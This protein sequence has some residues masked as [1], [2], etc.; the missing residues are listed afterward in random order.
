[1][2]SLCE[3]LGG[4][5]AGIAHRVSPKATTIECFPCWDIHIELW[6]LKGHAD[7]GVIPGMQSGSQWSRSENFIGGAKWL[8]GHSKVEGVQENV[9]LFSFTLININCQIAT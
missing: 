8:Q 2:M 6:C 9:C 5:I 1:M 4:I 7:R 3:H